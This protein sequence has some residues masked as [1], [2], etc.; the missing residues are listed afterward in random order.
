MWRWKGIR[1][2]ISHGYGEP[3]SLLLSFHLLQQTPQSAT[4][5][6]AI[7]NAVL[8]RAGL[9]HLWKDNAAV[10]VAMPPP[11]PTTVPSNGCPAILSLISTT[12]SPVL[13]IRKDLAIPKI[14]QGHRTV[15]MKPGLPVFSSRNYSE[16]C[17]MA[18]KAPSW[19]H[20]CGGWRNGLQMTSAVTGTAN[21]SSVEQ[22]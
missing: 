10:L 12:V 18:P 11:V 16:V 19:R 2:Q 4:A 22:Q 7:G 3:G 8:R 1:D 14:L 20:G 21:S 13:R 15:L 6:Q 5:L 17:L 9:S